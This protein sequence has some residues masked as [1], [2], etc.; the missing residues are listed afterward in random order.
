M[1]R[2]VLLTLLAAVAALGATASAAMDGETPTVTMTLADP[3][4]AYGSDIL[5]R[6]RVSAGGADQAVVVEQRRG[7]AW[8]RV[9]EARTIE[10]GRFLTSFK[11]AR[12]GPIRA[13]LAESGA[14]SPPAPLRVRP[15]LRISV[16]KGRA[17]LGARMV[18]RVQP[19]TYDGDLTAWIR[20]R[21]HD[22][23]LVRRRVVDG[24][25]RMRLPTPGVGRF[26]VRVVLAETEEFA[27]VRASGSVHA[28]ARDVAYGSSGKEV[29]ALRRRLAELRYRVPDETDVYGLELLDAVLA[30]QKANN[31]ARDGYVGEEVWRALGRARTPKPRHARPGYHIEVDKT[32]QILL[33]VRKGEVRAVIPVS[34][35]ATGNTP[36]GAFQIRWK[37]LATRTW[38]GP[39]LLYRTMTFLGNEFAIHGFPSVPAYPASHGCV[40]IPIWVA[41]WLYQ[42]S[43]VG[44]RIFIYR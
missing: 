44:T 23:A 21:G 9:T 43:P 6:G 39:A 30:F 4:V 15:L 1:R 42:R 14:L 25:L 12:G 17:F 18:V 38:L 41:D 26:R 40:R 34:T 33:V 20:K 19:T 11:A 29:R 37:A 35:G 2:R 13:R 7:S 32:R 3:A 28:G 8:T 31:L 36:E 16:R 24:V 22:R 10:G 27:P 5:A